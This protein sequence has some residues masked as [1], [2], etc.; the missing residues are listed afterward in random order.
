MSK[1]NYFFLIFTRLFFLVGCNRN[2]LIDEHE[3]LSLLETS[4]I[5]SNTK[6]ENP[7]AWDCATDHSEKIQTA[8]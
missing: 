2:S 8:L 3:K 7:H 4:S 1:K 5:L 6:L